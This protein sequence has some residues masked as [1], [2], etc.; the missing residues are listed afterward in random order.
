MSKNP[1]YTLHTSSKLGMY[2]L[3]YVVF[4]FT[5]IMGKFILIII[6]ILVTS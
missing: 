5:F 4:T 3:L 1:V 6:F 2:R